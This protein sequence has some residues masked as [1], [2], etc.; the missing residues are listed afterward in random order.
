[1]LFRS[2]VVYNKKSIRGIL[3]LTYR[4]KTPVVGFSKSYIKAGATTGL[5]STPEQIAI[6]AAGNIINFF[7]NNMKFSSNKYR[8]ES[9]S[10]DINTRVAKAIKLEIADKN[11][12]INSIIKSE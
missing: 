3:L 1:M 9:F 2:P 6:D 5:Y 12:I 4:N 7:R 8:P 11:G 10:M